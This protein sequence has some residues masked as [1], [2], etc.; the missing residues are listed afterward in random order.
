MCGRYSLTRPEETL[1][2]FLGVRDDV[3]GFRA[4]YNIAPTQVAPVV[5]ESSL[6]IRLA[7]PMRWGMTSLGGDPAH[8]PPLFNARSE[9]VRVK[10]SFAESFVRR[11]CL[12]PADG[13]YEW[14]QEGSVRQPYRITQADGGPFAFA[15]LWAPW[16]GEP[17]GAFTI[18]TTT[19]NETLAPI[20]DRMPVILPPA[21]H[22]AWLEGHN[23]DMLEA[24]LEP[25]PADRIKA[26]S[27]STLVNS[28]EHDDPA[29]LEPRE[30]VQP[31]LF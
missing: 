16:P 22:E 13:F 5:R 10:G 17:T 28:V 3:S 27:V 12:V 14:R 1:A 21:R 23:P 9:T 7:L 8:S 25:Y 4:R 31:S 24:L 26:F 2:E 15:G 20:H 6:G 29:C 30:P 19:A 11:R 18:L